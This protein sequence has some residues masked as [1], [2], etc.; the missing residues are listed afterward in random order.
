MKKV[1]PV[2]LTPADVGYVVFVPDLHINTEGIDVANAIEMARDAIGLWGICEE[3]MGRSIPSPSTL[4]PVCEANELVTLVDIDFDA[5]RRANDNRTIRKNLTIPSWLNVQA[6][7][8]GINFS[9]V[10]QSALK[11]QLGIQ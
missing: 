11:D 5:Y 9:Q 1:Y 6:E 4:H 2:V 10:L 7:K 3:D 8:A